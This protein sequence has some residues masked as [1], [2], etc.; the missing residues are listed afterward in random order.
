MI[1]AGTT[2]GRSRSPDG[3]APPAPEDRALEA[4]T[5]VPLTDASLMTN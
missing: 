1:T 3:R 5:R 2:H 4:V